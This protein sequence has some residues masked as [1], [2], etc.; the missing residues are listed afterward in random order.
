MAKYFSFLARLQAV[1]KRTA[2]WEVSFSLGARR[3]GKSSLS[4]LRSHHR[5]GASSAR[6]GGCV[7]SGKPQTL[8]EPHRTYF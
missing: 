1:V 8:S 5:D 7:T 4:T 6:G 3:E 2:G